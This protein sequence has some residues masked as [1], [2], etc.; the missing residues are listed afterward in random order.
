MAEFFRPSPQAQAF[1]LV[2]MGFPSDHVMSYSKARDLLN[3]VC[4]EGKIPESLVS[5][6][7][8]HIPHEYH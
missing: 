3:K 8:Q 1:G 2:T 6:H 7:V 4:E 5:V